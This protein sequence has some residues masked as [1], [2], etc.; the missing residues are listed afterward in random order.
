VKNDRN[1]NGYTLCLQWGYLKYSD[2]SPSE[3]GYRFI[4][5]KPDDKLQAARAQARIPSAAAMA[6]L[7]GRV[8]GRVLSLIR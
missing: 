6:G 2:G 3:Y 5:R 1:L 8:Y 7:V 4:Y